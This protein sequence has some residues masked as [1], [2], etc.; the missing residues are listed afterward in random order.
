MGSGSTRDPID[1]AWAPAGTVASQVLT[2]KADAFESLA[3]LAVVRC[4]TVPAATR[5]LMRVAEPSTVSSGQTALS[6]GAAL[7]A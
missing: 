5:R 1:A 4:G 2:G 6:A 7:P 3:A